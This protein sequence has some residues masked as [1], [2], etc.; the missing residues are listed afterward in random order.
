MELSKFNS[1]YLA[2]LLEK[3]SLENKTLVLLGDFNA[4]LLKFHRNSEFLNFLDSTYSFP[5]IHC[6]SISSPTH[7]TVTLIDNIF[8][9]SCNSRYTSTNLVITLSDYHVQYL[10]MRNQRNSSKN[11]KEG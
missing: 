4:D 3:L 6:Q 11:N 2:N 8:S 10:I 7:A 5:H 9:K 1:D